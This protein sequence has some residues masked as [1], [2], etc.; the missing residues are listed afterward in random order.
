M[1]TNTSFLLIIVL[2]NIVLVYPYKSNTNN[3]YSNRIISNVLRSIP[4]DINNGGNSKLIEFLNDAKSISS[5][6]H[7]VQG[8]GAILESIGSFENLRF[9][10]IP[11]KGNSSSQH[12]RIIIIIITIFL[13]NYYFHIIIIIIIR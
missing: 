7:V 8:P 6:R 13:S 12:H 3:K 9:T 4:K 11:N 5:V 10:D 1:I 2:L